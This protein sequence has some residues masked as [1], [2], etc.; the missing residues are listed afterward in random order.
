MTVDIAYLTRRVAILEGVVK[1]LMEVISST[2]T[3]WQLEAMSDIGRQANQELD[4]LEG[5]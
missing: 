5:K 3:P 1:A 4:K 2:A